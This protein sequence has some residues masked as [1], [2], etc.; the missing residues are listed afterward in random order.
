MLKRTVGTSQ[1]QEVLES[2]I[3]EALETQGYDSVFVEPHLIDSSDDDTPKVED[4]SVLLD[5]HDGFSLKPKKLIKE[6]QQNPGDPKAQGN[7][8]SHYTNHTATA[9]CVASAIEKKNG[10]L[11]DLDPTAGLNVEV[12][13]LQRS[14]LNPTSR[15]MIVS[16]IIN[17][18]K[19]ERAK[20]KEAKL[21]KCFM[22]GNTD[23]YSR[24]LK[25]KK[26]MELI[27]DYNY[28]AVGLAM[29]NAE[30]DANSKES[31]AKKLEEAA[32]MAKNKA[33]KNAEETNK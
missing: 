17:Q 24:T 16:D 14:L 3:C 2:W 15:D 23:S 21:K 29:L 9:H 31:A 11:I 32:D 5:E 30:K 25:D 19:V 10:R 27:V 7:L 8:F 4:D 12:S 20:K 1:H 26:S 18:A 13:E 6:F 28:M 33:S 22:N